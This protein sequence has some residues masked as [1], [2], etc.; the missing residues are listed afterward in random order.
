MWTSSL[1]VDTHCS[2]AAGPSYVH[3]PDRTNISLKRCTKKMVIIS[4]QPSAIQCHRFEMGNAL[5]SVYRW[6]STHRQQLVAT[7]TWKRTKNHR[8]GANMC[9]QTFDS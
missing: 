6:E 7:F 9:L 2:Q 4:W 1:M 8:L 3:I 5:R